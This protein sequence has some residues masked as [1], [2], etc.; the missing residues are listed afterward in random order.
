MTGNPRRLGNPEGFTEGAVGTEKGFILRR[1]RN[2]VSL[3]CSVGTADQAR[4]RL[5]GG[6]GL[7][8]QKE[9]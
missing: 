4:V 2:A 1:E 9:K 3:Q 5:V 8:M 6:G 7:E